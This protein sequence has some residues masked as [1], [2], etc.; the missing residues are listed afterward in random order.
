M[1]ITELLRDSA[2]GSI[3]YIIG[4]LL[5]TMID[6]AFYELYKKLDP[7]HK[8]KNILLRVII[9]QLYFTIALSIWITYIIGSKKAT[10]I[11]HNFFSL[12]YLSSQ[13][14]LFGD[15]VRSIARLVHLRADDAL[16]ID[17]RLKNKK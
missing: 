7:N 6:V 9:L 2:I 3:K 12:G 15:A 16:K 17:D 10:H 11:T 13:I 14:F 8:N 4:F 1:N 5:G